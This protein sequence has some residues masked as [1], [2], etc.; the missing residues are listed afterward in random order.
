MKRL[1]IALLVVSALLVA[2]VQFAVAGVTDGLV[3]HFT[4]SEGSGDATVDSVAGVKAPIENPVW[5]DGIEGSALDF[6][7]AATI[8]DEDKT[9]SCLIPAESTPDLSEGFTMAVWVKMTEKPAGWRAFLFRGQYGDAPNAKGFHYG[10]DSSP[11]FYFVGSPE[12]SWT[13]LNPPDTD[14]PLEID[15]WYYYSV[16]YDA[17]TGAVKKYLNG[18]LHSETV[19]DGKLHDALDEPIRIGGKWSD[20]L[21]NEYDALPAVIDEVK[22]W[23]RPLTPDEVAAEYSLFG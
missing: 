5:T 22:I 10:V 12:G 16:T 17:G 21:Y 13:A 11:K 3:L 1:A 18:E 20:D 8:F 15:K 6:N 7:R 2:T 4:F 9:I 23:T 19:W 14:K